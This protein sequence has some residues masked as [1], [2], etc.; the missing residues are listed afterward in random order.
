MTD[1][2]AND[3]AALDER[4]VAYLDGELDP[5]SSR[6]VED[7]LAS[8][9]EIRGKLQRLDHTWELLDELDQAPPA[10]RF[11]QSTLEMVAVEAEEELDRLQTEAPRRRRRRWLLTGGGIVVAGLAGYAV[12][13]MFMPDPDRDLIRDLPVLENFDQYRRID[14]VEF[15][16]ELHEQ[17][18]F[19]EEE[20]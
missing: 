9:P 19:A 18:L 6:Q 2:P 1:E 8:D 15:L 11:T 20:E 10:D 5:E 13:A 7:L 3:E 16:R 4:L 12:V 14:D 17:G